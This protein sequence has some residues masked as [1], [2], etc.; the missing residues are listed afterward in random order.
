MVFV[1]RPILLPQ[2]LLHFSWGH[3]RRVL[4]IIPRAAGFH[5]EGLFV[6]KPQTVR[7]V[8]CL[9]VG[10]CFFCCRCCCSCCCRRSCGFRKREL[11]F[12][13][14]PGGMLEYL[15]SPSRREN[16]PSRRFVSTSSS[17]QWSVKKV[18]IFSLRWNTIRLNFRIV[19]KHYFVHLYLLYELS[20]FTGWFKVTFFFPRSLE[21][22]N[23]L[24]EKGHVNSPS[25][26]GHKLA[27]LPGRHWILD[28]IWMIHENRH[29]FCW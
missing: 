23:N 17:D 1:L 14:F 6:G 4:E 25:Q 29:D 18:S 15:N 27:E 10:C 8:G 13:F 11:S 9:F 21:V 2:F 3:E 5:R 19:T 20:L 16:S 28:T 12:V 26:K 22:T 7:V 24:L